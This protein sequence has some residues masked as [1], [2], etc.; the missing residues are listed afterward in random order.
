MEIGKKRKS[1]WRQRIYR[2]YVSWNRLQKTQDEIYVDVVLSRSRGSPGQWFPETDYLCASVIFVVGTSG[3][4]PK[5]NYR[6]VKSYNFFLTSVVCKIRCYFMQS[7]LNNILKKLLEYIS[8]IIKVFHKGQNPY[9][10]RVEFMCLLILCYNIS[11]IKALYSETIVF[12]SW[13][14]CLMCWPYLSIH[15]FVWYQL[16]S[17]DEWILYYKY[18]KC[19]GQVVKFPQYVLTSELKVFCLVDKFHETES[20]QDWKISG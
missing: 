18:H 9:S 12:S 8:R 15:F 13:N 3:I 7:V 17:K 19:V 2:K 10:K 14:D 16:C 6:S 4:P 5:L 11:H 1:V 20:V